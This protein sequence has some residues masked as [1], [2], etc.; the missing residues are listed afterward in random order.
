[1][2]NQTAERTNFKVVV[3][4]GGSTYT[5]SLNAMRNFVW[6]RHLTKFATIQIWPQ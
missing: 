6:E 2:L 1:M 4:R 3:K 5:A